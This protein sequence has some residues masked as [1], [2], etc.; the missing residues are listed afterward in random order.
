MT[1]QHDDLTID[2]VLADPLIL[3]LR[4][5]DGVEPQAF[6]AL[7][8]SAAQDRTRERRSGERVA[9]AE[10]PVA[11]SDRGALPPAHLCRTFMEGWR[12]GRTCHA[13]TLGLRG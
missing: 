1:L 10:R 3:A 4:R 13:K 6:E 7:L 9:S 2:D 12:A 11:G 5:A 8:R